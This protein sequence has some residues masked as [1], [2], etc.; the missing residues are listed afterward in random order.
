MQGSARKQNFRV[1]QVAGFP[2][3]HNQGNRPARTEGFP[4]IVPGKMQQ[5]VTLMLTALSR[6]NSL[7]QKPKAK[8]NCS[9]ELR[10]AHD[11]P[12]CSRAD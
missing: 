8:S 12:G 10:K 7:R 1:I 4:R 6:F 11:I 2:G 5:L 3:Q 9:G